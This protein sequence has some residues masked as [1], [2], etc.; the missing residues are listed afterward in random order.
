MLRPLCLK[1][2]DRVK[3]IRALAGDKPI[4][5]ESFF[6]DLI[7]TSLTANAY[8][9]ADQAHRLDLIV[10]LLAHRVRD[11]AFGHYSPAPEKPND[12]LDFELLFALP[13]PAVICTGDLR[14]IDL[15][16]RLGRGDSGKVM[17]PDEIYLWLAKGRLPA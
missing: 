6:V 7:Q 16:R 5:D 13:L 11:A 9:D 1:Y 12:R 17:T 2:P 3:R 15:V 8:L 14:F 4:P 10:H